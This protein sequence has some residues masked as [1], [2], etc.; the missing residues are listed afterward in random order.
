[1][2]LRTLACL[3]LAGLFTSS[4][5][6]AELATKKALTLDAAKQ[7]MA[8][9]EAHA[10]KNNWNVCI[11][12]LDDGGHLVAFQRMDNVQIGSVDVAIAKAE[13]A[14]RFKR[15]TKVFEDAVANRAGLLR[16]TGAMPVEGGLPIEVDGQVIGSIGVSGVASN[17]DAMIGQA[18]IDALSR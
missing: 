11:A 14:I 9:A 2:F 3:A 7:M 17:Q 10:K 16:L 6:A 12:I 5:F 13:S 18:G 4:G 15:S 8:A 1:M